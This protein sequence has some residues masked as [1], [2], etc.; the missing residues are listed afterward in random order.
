LK[1][2]ISLCLF[3]ACICFSNVS[4]NIAEILEA[5]PPSI[6]AD[7]AFHEGRFHDALKLYSRVPLPE[8]SQYGMAQ[9]HEMLQQYDKAIEAYKLILQN[10]PNHYKAMENLAGLYERYGRD[11]RESIALYSRALEMDPRPEWQSYLKTGIKILE[12]QLRNDEDHCVGL[13]HRGMGALKSGR[14]EDAKNGFS[15]AIERN[16]RMYQAYFARGLSNIHLGNSEDALRDFRETVKLSPT[17]RGA[18]M[19]LALVHESLGNKNEALKY[20]NEAERNDPNDPE[21]L[22]HLGRLSEQYND[23]ERALSS[24]LR[25]LTLHAKPEL[26]KLINERVAGLPNR[27]ADQKKKVQVVQ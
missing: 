7:K 20:L 12:S 18:Y 22:F 23:I 11:P 16:S 8:V 24:Y 2:V 13:F 14:Y 21:A 10:C 27:K 26:R 4:G 3:L 17:F 1:I 15:K 5:D 19:Q 25:A 6:M 9:C